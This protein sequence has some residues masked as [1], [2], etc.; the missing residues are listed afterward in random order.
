MVIAWQ[1]KVRTKRVDKCET[2][3]PARISYPERLDDKNM[4]GIFVKAHFAFKL[5]SEWHFSFPG[6]QFGWNSIL[7]RTERV[8]FRGENGKI[9][10]FRNYLMKNLVIMPFPFLG[11][12]GE[13]ILPRCP[14]IPQIRRWRRTREKEDFHAAG[15]RA[16]QRGGDTGREKIQ[17]VF[18]FKHGLR[19][20][21]SG[22]VLSF[23]RGVQKLTSAIEEKVGRIWEQ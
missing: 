23:E 14:K 7:R 13:E 21:L 1:Q 22:S 9:F 10:S 3:S 18:S 15:R 12:F 8:G 16:R 5:H 17:S 4:W 20:D 19:K 11:R 6:F 2:L